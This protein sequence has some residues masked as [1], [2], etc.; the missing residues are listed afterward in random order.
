MLNALHTILL[1]EDDEND[2]IITKR[3]I[4]KAQIQVENLRTARTVAEAIQLITVEKPD[5]VLLDLNLP[6]SQGLD[7][8]DGIRSVYDGVVIVLTSIDNEMIGV[9]AI[10]HGADDYIVK[11]QLNEYILSRSI[12]YAL[13][14]KK[15]YRK[16]DKLATGLEKLEQLQLLR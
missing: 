11:L 5:I 15:M 12:Y 8:L 16:V 7:T 4:V 1:V 14:R 10:K 9:E 2:V 13:E 6:D 3:K